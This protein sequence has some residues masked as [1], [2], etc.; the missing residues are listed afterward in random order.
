MSYT[1]LTTW[2]GYTPHEIK[3][4]IGERRLIIWGQGVLGKELSNLYAKNGINC[5]IWESSAGSP[6][7]LQRTYE[8]QGIRLF[9]IIASTRY[10]TEIEAEFKKW[11]LAKN[12]DYFTPYQV[13]RREAKIEKGTP[14][15]EEIEKW[16]WQNIPY[17]LSVRELDEEGDIPS[18]NAILD[19]CVNGTQYHSFSKYDVPAALEAAQKE[20]GKPCLCQRVWPIF[21]RAG[22]VA[23]CDCFRKVMTLTNNLAN[24]RIRNSIESA[25]RFREQHISACEICQKYCLHRLRLE[26]F[27]K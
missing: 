20:A 9:F 21:M 23:L 19:Y 4:H 3:E 18:Y 27:K 17:L 24:D 2:Y 25:I 16:C 5:D 1:P 13:A 7:Q 6:Y 26:N 10:C 15:Y 22:Y 8:A 14:N 12:R 11:K